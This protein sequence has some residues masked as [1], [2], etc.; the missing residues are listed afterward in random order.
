MDRSSPTA[1]TEEGIVVTQEVLDPG[2]RSRVKIPNVC[3]AFGIPFIDTFE[4]LR[5]LRVRFS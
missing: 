1:R 3:Q 4:M 2:A 5:R